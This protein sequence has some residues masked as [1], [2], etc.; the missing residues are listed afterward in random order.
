M[1]RQGLLKSMDTAEQSGV[2]QKHIIPQQL[3]HL[4]NSEYAEPL[5][6]G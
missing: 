5:E 4:R 3:H 2:E 6:V 1:G